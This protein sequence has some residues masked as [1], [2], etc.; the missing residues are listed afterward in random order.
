MCGHGRGI[1][2]WRQNEGVFTGRGAHK[3]SSSHMH[4]RVLCYFF[5]VSR[6]HKYCSL[7]FIDV[8]YSCKTPYSNIFNKYM[9]IIQTNN[10]LLNKIE[11]TINL[12]KQHRIILNTSAASSGS[13]LGVCF[14]RLQKL[15][16]F[17]LFPSTASTSF[18]ANLVNQHV[19]SLKGLKQTLDQILHRCH[20]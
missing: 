5:K 12:N 14:C 15:H 20:H 10:I 3:S 19:C 13:K 8:I 2:K 6:V 11:P 17:M 7:L 1:G 16:N 4:W 9:H 18:F